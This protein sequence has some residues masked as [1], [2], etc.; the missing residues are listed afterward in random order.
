MR[1]DLVKKDKGEKS[2]FSKKC[3]IIYENALK[4]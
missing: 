3:K 1:L 4:N 2:E